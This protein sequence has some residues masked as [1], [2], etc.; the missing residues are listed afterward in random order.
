MDG[1]HGDAAR[2]FTVGQVEQSSLDL[3]EACRVA[4]WQGIA[5]A[6]GRRVRIGD[7]SAAIE[8]SIHG[9][10]RGYGII[11][12]YTGHG[13][14]SA[15]HQA[16]DVPNWGSRGSGPRVKA[17]MCLAIEPMITISGEDTRELDDDW[18]V[19]TAT[20]ARAAHW[21]NTVA[22]LPNGLWV[23]TEPDGGEAELTALGVAFAPLAD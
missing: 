6:A 8:T 18:T 17:G 1:W 10:Q 3:I 13:I 19:V 14:G 23:L 11:R 7:I 20:G 15:M 5:A 16:P 22:V 21:E 9:Y 4:T 12:E 2:T